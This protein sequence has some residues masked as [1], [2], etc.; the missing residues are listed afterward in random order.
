MLIHLQTSRDDRFFTWTLS[1]FCGVYVSLGLSRS[2]STFVSRCLVR[3]CL[4]G[5]CVLESFMPKLP[6]NAAPLVPSKRPWQDP[7]TSLPRIPSSMPCFLP[8][9]HP[10]V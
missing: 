8:F 1:F 6:H 3:F 7:S 2:G 5:L 9:S 4:L 10:F